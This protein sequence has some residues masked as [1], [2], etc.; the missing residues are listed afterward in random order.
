MSEDEFDYADLS[1]GDVDID[2]MFED[3]MD[4]NEI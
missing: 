3:E 4:K 1:N 2:E